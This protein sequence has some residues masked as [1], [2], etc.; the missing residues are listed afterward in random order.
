MVAVPTWARA[1][2]QLQQYWIRASLAALA[3]A[4]AAYWTYRRAPHA[5]PAPYLWLV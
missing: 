4:Y 3:G 1:P 5:L 2:S